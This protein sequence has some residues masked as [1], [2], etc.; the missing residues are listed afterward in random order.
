[1]LEPSSR[2]EKGLIGV[3]GNIPFFVRRLSTFNEPVYELLN[4]AIDVG[5]L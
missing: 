5:G 4:D 2:V 3:G 1:M